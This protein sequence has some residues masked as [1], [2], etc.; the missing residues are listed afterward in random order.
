MFSARPQPRL[1]SEVGRASVFS[2]TVTPLS[3]LSS[4]A[5]ITLKQATRMQ[6]P[7][8]TITRSAKVALVASFSL[9]LVEA[10]WYCYVTLRERGY[11]RG[12]TRRPSDQISE[13]SPSPASPL[14]RDFQPFIVSEVRQETHNVKRIR[15]ALLPEQSLDLPPGCHIQVCVMHNGE[16]AMKHY[17]PVTTNKTKGYFE[18]A[19][20]RYEGGRVSTKMH[21]LKPGDSLLSAPSSLR[22]KQTLPSFSPSPLYCCSSWAYWPIP[23][24]GERVR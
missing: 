6:Q 24:Q 10:I 5:I 2:S 1:V 19:V 8:V 23:V 22:C 21:E 16:K 13:H 12:E 20:K 14:S 9:C 17:T 15:F 4:F 3:L 11:F 7:Q 18:L